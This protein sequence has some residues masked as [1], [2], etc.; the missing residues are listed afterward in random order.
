MFNNF[1][2]CVPV[3]VHH[4][5][6]ASARNRARIAPSRTRRSSRRRNPIFSFA[7]WLSQ[8]PIQMFRA[9]PGSDRQGRTR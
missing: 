9:R 2:F 8:S 6:L 3:S 4:G 7:L 5:S 1:V